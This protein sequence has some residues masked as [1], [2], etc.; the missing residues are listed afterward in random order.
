LSESSDDEDD[1]NEESSPPF[2]GLSRFLLS[3]VFFKDPL[4]RLDLLEFDFFDRLECNDFFDRLEFDSTDVIVSVSESESLDDED[5]DDSDEEEESLSWRLDL[6]FL[7][8]LFFEWRLI[9]LERD[10]FL[11]FGTMLA[12]STIICFCLSF[13]DGAPV[14]P[15]RRAYARFRTES[16]LPWNLLVSLFVG[17]ECY[18][19]LSEPPFFVQTSIREIRGSLGACASLFDK[20]FVEKWPVIWL[21]FVSA[22]FWVLPES[23]IL[24]SWFVRNARLSAAVFELFTFGDFQ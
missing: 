12:V 6:L 17:M 5:D 19:V 23:G 24:V 20:S 14:Y 16:L 3:F 13:I 15:S 10:R 8:R 2:R 22:K 21:W 11:C 18:S 4:L 9:L 7:S 1:D